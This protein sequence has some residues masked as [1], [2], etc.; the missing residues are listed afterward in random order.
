[1]SKGK[2]DPECAERDHHHD[3]SASNSTF[4][5]FI[6]AELENEEG[7]MKEKIEDFSKAVISQAPE[8]RKGYKRSRS[9]D[10][11]EKVSDE[12]EKS[13]EEKGG[14]FNGWF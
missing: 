1:M 8:Y 13:P 7:Y 5:D 4:E 11:S 9:E 3:H 6:D 12:G 2:V 14:F 10:Q